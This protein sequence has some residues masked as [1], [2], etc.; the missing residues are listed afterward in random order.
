MGTN[1]PVLYPTEA[2]MQRPFEEYIERIEAEAWHHG[3]AIIQPPPSWSP[4]GP[5]PSRVS[6]RNRAGT[7]QAHP[8]PG[9]SPAQACRPLGGAAGAAAT[10]AATARAPSGAARPDQVGAGHAAGVQAQAGAAAA[11]RLDAEA[12]AEAAVEPLPGAGYLGPD[13]CD[14]DDWII[15]Q[16]IRQ[17]AAGSKGVFLSIHVVESKGIP[18]REFRAMAM[19]PQNCP[20]PAIAQDPL[21]LERAF[22]KNVTHSPPLYGADGVGS[23]FS[24]TRVK[25]W[26]VAKLGTLLSRRLEEEGQSIPG[27]TTAYLYFGMWRSV[28]AWYA[29]A[30]LATPCPVC[31]RLCARLWQLWD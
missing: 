3:I 18:V 28:F 29:Q 14:L 5:V 13:G 23:L 4:R 9:G 20:P 6:P 7:P 31:V 30:A 21:S 19:A 10:P 26:N 27:V 24:A 1:V 22:W 15:P 16:P 17:H 2:D 25:E 11:A 12:G 8:G